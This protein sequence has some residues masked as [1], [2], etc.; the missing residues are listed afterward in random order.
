MTSYRYT[1]EIRA[2]DGRDLGDFPVEPDWLPAIE[3]TAFEGVR[4]GHFETLEAA[5][6]GAVTPSWHASL[7]EPYVERFRVRVGDELATEL[8]TSY[9]AADARRVSA[10]LVAGGQLAAGETFTYAVCAFAGPDAGGDDDDLDVEPLSAAPAFVDSSLR[11]WIAAAVVHGELHPDDLPVFV[12]RHVLDEAV[13]RAREAGDVETGGV[14]LGR[15][16]RDRRAPE[17]FV[18]ITAQIPA[19]SVCAAATRLTFT[20]ETWAAADAARALRRRGE[21]SLAWWH[22]HPWFCTRCPEQRRRL[23][24]FARSVFSHDDVHLH[25]VCFGR[26]YQV[27]LLLSDHGGDALEVA[28]Y[29]WRRGVVEERGFYVTGD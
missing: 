17:V 23:C 6:P 18:E 25:R 29:G 24:V 3:G 9:L 27:A 26:P 15:L 5:P 1:L 22:L 14:L 2:A 13:A 12:P 7:G 20:P 11:E 21:A 8:G 28:L 10:A 16:H 19:A 4:R